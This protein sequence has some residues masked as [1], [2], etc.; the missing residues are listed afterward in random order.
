MVQMVAAGGPPD[1]S[2]VGGPSSFSPFNDIATDRSRFNELTSRGNLYLGRVFYEQRIG[3]GENYLMGRAGIIDLSDYF[4]TNLFANNEARQFVNSSFVNSA[5][6]KAAISA[7]GVMAAYHR[8][9]KRDWLEGVVVRAGYAV[10]RTDRAFTSPIWMGELELQTRLQGHRG[11][12][13]FGGS[14]G[15]RADVG[16]VRGLHISLDHWVAPRIGLFGRYGVANA[17]V[18]SLSFGPVRQSYSGG[19]QVRFVDSQDRV[20]AWS[21]G[22]SQAYGII[23]DAPLSSERILETYYRWQWTQNFALS[24]DFQFILGSGGRLRQGNQAVLGL[25]FN[26]TF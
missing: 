3:L 21:L 13:R 18:G 10:S 19:V 17:S 8:R 7:P 16:S 2:S 22:F 20:S 23:T 15:S 12:W 5:A 6:Y 9:V 25:R 14:V 24:P 11:N 1:S 26:F 4:D